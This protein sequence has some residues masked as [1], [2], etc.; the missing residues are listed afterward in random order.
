MGGNSQLLLCC[1]AVFFQSKAAVQPFALLFRAPV[2]LRNHLPPRQR[3]ARSS[4]FPLKPPFYHIALLCV[5]KAVPGFGKGRAH[6]YKW[7]RGLSSSS[8]PA[9]ARAANFNA[10]EF[11]QRHPRPR[12]CAQPTQPQPRQ[13]ERRIRPTPV[14]IYSRPACCC[15]RKGAPRISGALFCV[16]G[17]GL[18]SGVFG[19][20]YLDSPE[21]QPPTTSKRTQQKAKKSPESTKAHCHTALP[22]HGPHPGTT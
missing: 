18:S 13:L 17:L 3:V 8:S 11:T 19:G 14:H 6:S 10:R 9:L 1:V 21:P 7:L 4:N 5:L 12:T 20:M 15:L 22:D 16:F 2:S